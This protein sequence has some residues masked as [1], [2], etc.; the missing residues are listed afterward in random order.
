M[1]AGAIGRV[2]YDYAQSREAIPDGVRSLPV[3]PQ[4]GCLAR[5]HQD[6]L[7]LLL[8]PVAR[9]F[10][11]QDGVLGRHA[12][13]HDQPDLREYVVLVAGQEQARALRYLAETLP[14]RQQ[15]QVYIWPDWF[16]RSSARIRRNRKSR[17]N[18]WNR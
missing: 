7:P 8:A 2:L 4:A 14:L 9:K 16:G 15:P 17:W 3:A 11:N 6:F 5:R 13:Q 10:H 18:P 1:P 12:N